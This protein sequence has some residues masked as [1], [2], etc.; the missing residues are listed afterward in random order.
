MKGDAKLFSGR[1]QH[2][3]LLFF[4]AETWANPLIGWSWRSCTSWDWKSNSNKR[5]FSLNKRTHTAYANSQMFSLWLAY[6]GV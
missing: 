1:V 6:C 4:A 5:I 3:E 2:E